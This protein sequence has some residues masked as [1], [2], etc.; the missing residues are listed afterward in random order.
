MRDTDHI[1]RRFA[2]IC[3]RAGVPVMEVYA[4]PFTVGQKADNSL[5]TEA[6]ERAETLILEA[7]ARDF[8]GVPV[9][10]E[11][12]FAAGLRPLIDGDFLL[13]DPVDGTKEFISKNGEFTINI[14]LVSGRRPV[15]GCVYA[16][17]LERI[18]LGDREAWAGGLKPGGQ[19]DLRALSPISTRSPREGKKV[20]VMSRSHADDTT[21]AFAEAQGVTDTV[22]AGSS[23][24]F[25][26]LA[27]GKADIY[28]RFAPT[29][30]WDTGAGHAVLN[31]AGGRVTDPDGRDF[32]YGKVEADYLNG[33]FVAWAR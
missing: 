17:A 33:P 22:S 14:A 15:A 25:C 18:Y 11:E 3:A 29:R 27:E 4:R 8:P 12:S 31:A 7:L 20:A 23:L 24:K 13:V 5:V 19:F 2:A 28:P 6:D 10:A 32:L 9:L 21:R 30:E 16:P 1:A 26:L